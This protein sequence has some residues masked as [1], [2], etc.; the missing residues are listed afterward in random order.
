VSPTPI[1][2]KP[3]ATAA[4]PV[5]IDLGTLGGFDSFAYDINELRQIV[6][7]SDIAST[8]GAMPS[9]GTRA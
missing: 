5:I 8:S 2:A 4:R 7:E 9:N 3:I 6:G 1:S